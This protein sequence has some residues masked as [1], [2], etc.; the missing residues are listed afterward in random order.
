MPGPFDPE[1]LHGSGTALVHGQ[2]VGEVDD[3]VLCAVNDQHRRG[4][5]GDLVNASRQERGRKKKDHRLHTHCNWVSILGK[6][7]TCP[8]GISPHFSIVHFLKKLTLHFTIILDL[9]ERYKDNTVLL[10]TPK[11]LP[12][13]PTM[14]MIIVRL[15]KPKNQQWYVTKLQTLFEFYELFHWSPISVPGSNWEYHNAVSHCVFVKVFY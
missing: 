9:Q 3:L 4:D 11:P 12:I 15:S 1:R 10:S 6:Q 5:F 8:G 7:G 14:H 13:R 2:A